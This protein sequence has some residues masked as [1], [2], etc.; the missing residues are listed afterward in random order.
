MTELEREIISKECIY[1]SMSAEDLLLQLTLIEGQMNTY[2]EVQQNAYMYTLQALNQAQVIDDV[3]FERIEKDVKE[4]HDTYTQKAAEQRL[5]LIDVKERIKRLVLESGESVSTEY[6]SAVYM[7]GRVSWNTAGLEGYAI[8][9]QDILNFR[10]EGA[11]YVV[12]KN[13]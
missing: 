3:T 13:K 2:L 6:N 8:A 4:M 7:P 9:N 10:K 1:D 11:P 12:F 5:E